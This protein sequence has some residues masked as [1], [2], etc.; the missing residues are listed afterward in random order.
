M[1]RTARQHDC[2]EELRD[3]SLKVTPAR[4]A[5]LRLLEK[6]EGPIDVKTIVDYLRK[7]DSTVDQA[8][9]FRIMNTFTDRGI[10]KKIQ[11]HESKFRYELTSI[12]EHHHLICTICGKIEDI[13]DCNI[14]ALERDIRKKKE[15]LVESHS[16]EFFGVCNICQS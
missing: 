2:K 1:V 16:L 3:V 11:L 4:L 7:Q 14:E 12:A 6:E 13:S 8:T 9:V 15:F 10:T 5:V